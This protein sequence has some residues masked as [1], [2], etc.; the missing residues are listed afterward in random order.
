MSDALINS[1]VDELFKLDDGDGN[2]TCEEIVQGLKGKVTDHQ[3]KEFITFLDQDGDGSLTRKEVF[4]ALKKLIEKY[5]KQWVLSWFFIYSKIFIK[6]AKNRPEQN[7]NRK[8]FETSSNQL[9]NLQIHFS[10]WLSTVE[11]REL[12]PTELQLMKSQ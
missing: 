2:L 9:E 10:I 6:Y 4:D 8:I 3:A 1:I 11:N 5:S 12:C 7:S